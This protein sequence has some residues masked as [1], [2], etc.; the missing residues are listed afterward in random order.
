M[1]DPNLNLTKHMGIFGFTG[2]GKSM[3]AGWMFEQL[4]KQKRPFVLFDTKVKNH[5]GLCQMKGVTLLQIAPGKTYNWKRTLKTSK[6]IV[7]TPVKETKRS[8]LIAQYEKFAEVIFQTEDPRTLGIEEAH[9][10]N[11]FG[12]VAN[13]ILEN[14]I[15]EGRAYNQNLICIDQRIQSFPKDL[16]SQCATS[17]ICKMGIPQ[18]IEYLTRLIP[19]FADQNL[20]LPRYGAL[21]YDHETGQITGTLHPDRIHRITKHYG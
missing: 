14:I 11:P 18:D 1:T 17:V 13:E 3:K 20:S 15:R 12:N 21:I 6:Y 7:A 10:W 4:R 9:L 8:D 16:W 19:D 2:S 5:V